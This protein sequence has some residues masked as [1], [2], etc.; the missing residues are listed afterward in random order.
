MTELWTPKIISKAP[1][2]DQAPPQKKQKAAQHR[3]LGSPLGPVL[4]L[5]VG[6]LAPPR[7]AL[8]GGVGV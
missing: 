8:C 4:L 7:G 2:G 5:F 3:D 1:W 6:G